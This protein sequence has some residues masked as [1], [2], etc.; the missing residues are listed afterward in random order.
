MIAL[1]AMCVMTSCKS[2]EEEAIAKLDD[3]L[4]RVE[5]Q[6]DEMSQ[7]DWEKIYADY[8][9]IGLDNE[10]LNFTDEQRE[11]VGRK[12]GQL[13]TEY[14]EHTGKNLGRQIQ[15]AVKEG[16]GFVKGLIQGDKEE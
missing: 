5:R 12:T 11:M 1:V 14:A 16:I 15:E 10:E 6:G 8:Q 13:L 4:E 7:D 9:S 2:N 3:L